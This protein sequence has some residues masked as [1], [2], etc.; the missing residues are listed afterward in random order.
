M[1]INRPDPHEAL[2]RLRDRINHLLADAETPTAQRAFGDEP[3]WAPRVDISEAADEIIVEADLCGL[4]Q[5][6]IEVEITGD[7]LT[8]SGERKPDFEAD[9][10]I[11]RAERRFGPFSR[12]FAIGADIEPE[13]ARASLSQ[14]VLALAIPRAKERPATEIKVQVE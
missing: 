5:D 7:T 10:R 4:D 9:E 2:F 6:E 13:A 14:G 1:R 12:S 3:V 11:H 8:I